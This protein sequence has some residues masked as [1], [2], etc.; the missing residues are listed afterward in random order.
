MGGVNKVILV[1]RLGID[2][3]SRET[4]AGS[5]VTNFTLATSETWTQDGEK[6]ER[7]EWHRIVAWNRQAEICRDYLNKGSQVYI[8]GRLQTRR[9]TDENEVERFTTEIVLKDLQFLTR[10]R[11][12]RVQDPAKTIPS[13]SDNRGFL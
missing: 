13:R 9:W 2:P 6:Q 12:P 5:T 7:T 11:I 1:G 4:P 3:E 8:E 10:K